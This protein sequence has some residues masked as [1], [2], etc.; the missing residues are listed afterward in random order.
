M[1]FTRRGRK[2]TSSPHCH[3][4][5]SSGIKHF[6]TVQTNNEAGIR[7]ECG[8]VPCVVE[9]FHYL[10]QA[11]ERTQQPVRDPLYSPSVKS[12]M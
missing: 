4:L 2:G 12:L 8:F 3:Y 7:Y 6:V 1:N 9:P 10:Q 5:I 11:T